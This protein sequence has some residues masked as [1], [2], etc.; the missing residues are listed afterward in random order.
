MVD[1][2]HVSSIIT[3]FEHWKVV[4]TRVGSV[5]CTPLVTRISSVLGLLNKA[6]VLI[7]MAA[8]A[9]SCMKKILCRLRVAPDVSLFTTF[10]WLTVAGLA[11]GPLGL[12]P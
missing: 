8:I 5:E 11:L 10:P 4:F 3:T 1:R 12:W 2:I 9:N 7:L 6:I